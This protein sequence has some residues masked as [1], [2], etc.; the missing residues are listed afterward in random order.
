MNFSNYLPF[1]Y[2]V[3]SLAII[4]ASKL[5]FENCGNVTNPFKVNSL[6][7]LDDSLSIPGNVHLNATF[8]F[9]RD[10]SGPIMVC[11]N[12]KLKTLIVY[13]LFLNV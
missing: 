3:S 12:Y 5:T 10:I 1:V 7:L 6:N 8:S 2:L 13:Y 11:I 9:D 4:S